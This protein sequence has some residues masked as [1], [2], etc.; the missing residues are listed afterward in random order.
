MNIN[1][2]SFTGSVPRNLY[3]LTT[4]T[5]YRKM[6]QDGFITPQQADASG[7]NIFM[8]ELNNF[9]TKW[10]N[11]VY[12]FYQGQQIQA[13]GNPN[14][15]PIFFDLHKLINK[16]GLPEAL[17]QRMYPDN[18]VRALVAKT[19]PMGIDETVVLKIPTKNLDINN[20]FIRDQLK[21]NN[22]IYAKEYKE[23]IAAFKQHMN[24]LRESLEKN[25]CTQEEYSKLFSDE[26]KKFI[27]DKYKAL[28][29]G[30]TAKKSKLY[31]MQGKAIEYLYRK[32]ID[33]KQTEVAGKLDLT[34]AQISLTDT[35]DV[36]KTLLKML[37]K[38]KGEQKAIEQ[39]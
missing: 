11:I 5:N 22:F 27:P 12:N 32:P 38:G 10:K 21:S 19:N 9:V 16:T 14:N 15:V 24:E 23:L 39:F 4:A 29:L 31:K 26:F 13:L 28:I 25:I 20:L 36:Y 8:I 33:I 2:I 34:T 1:Q 35:H 6:L 17:L 37:F 18:L 7:A 30:D 3:H